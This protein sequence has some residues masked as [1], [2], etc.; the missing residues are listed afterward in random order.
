LLTYRTVPDRS[1]DVDKPRNPAKSLTADSTVEQAQPGSARLFLPDKIIRS[2]RRTGFSEGAPPE[3]L[4]VP[5][6]G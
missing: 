2:V 4:I 5:F 6:R 3:C 1:T